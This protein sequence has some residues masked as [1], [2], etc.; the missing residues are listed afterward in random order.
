MWLSPRCGAEVLAQDLSELSSEKREGQLAPLCGRHM[1]WPSAMCRACLT[2]IT[3][4]V[5]L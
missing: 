2:L 4:P 5:D 1:S 3:L